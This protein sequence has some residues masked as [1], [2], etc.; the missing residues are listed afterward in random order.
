[1]VSKSKNTKGKFEV[2]SKKG[3]DYKKIDMI[4]SNI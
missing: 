2:D 3:N 4:E 1:M